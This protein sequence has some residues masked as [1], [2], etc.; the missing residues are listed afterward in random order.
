[1]SFIRISVFILCITLSGNV[2]AEA[3]SVKNQTYAGVNELVVLLHGLARTE[4]SMQPMEKGLAEQG[5]VVVNIR[6][7]STE[8]PVERLAEM[9]AKDLE[10]KGVWAVQKVHFTTH[11]MGGIVLRQMFAKKHPENLGR[12]VMLCPPNK[13][14]EI[15]DRL[16]DNWL[17]KKINGPAGQQ[18][19]SNKDS[20]PNSLGPVD[21]QVGV[22]TGDKSFNP[23]FSSWLEGKDDGKVS[24]QRA[25]LD[26]M[27]DFFIL[28]YSHTFFMG[29][30]RVIVQTAA[31]L[32]T[33]RFFRKE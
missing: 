16:G 5:Y 22:I 20:L 9:V 11:S 26:G 1:M 12:V 18:L 3:E 15:V 17:F 33:G 19:G 24:V 21:Y 8:H 32:K 28:P 25:R 10:E 30:Q 7:P 6:Y 13:G 27:T 4:K 29:K 31:F 2:Y 14:S 23:L